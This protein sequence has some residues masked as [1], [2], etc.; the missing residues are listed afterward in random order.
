[1]A[2]D[3]LRGRQTVIPLVNKSGGSVA[4]NDVV[5]LDTANAGAFT[6]TT[7][8]AYSAGS[9]GV[10]LETIASNATG[11]VCTAGYVPGIALNASATLGY[12]VKTHTVAKQ[13]TSVSAIATGVFAQVLGTG[14]APAA[15]LYGGF[16][17]QGAGL[18]DEYIQDLVA[19][20]AVAGTNMTITYN[21]GAGTLT[22]D[23]AGGS[24]TPVR[25]RVYHNATQNVSNNTVTALAFNS[26]QVD[27]SGYHDNATN[28]PRL[29]VPSGQGGLH[30]I[31]G[32]IEFGG[33]NTTGIRWLAIRRNGTD[34]L[35][36]QS[37]PAQN[38]LTQISVTTDIEL[39]AT[40]YVELVFNQTSGGTITVAAGSSPSNLYAC[41]FS[42]TRLGS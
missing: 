12:F 19:A 16:P 26:E 31:K 33:A 35:A 8:G 42:I 40:D 28:N 36:V 3:L 9:I 10:V 1:M 34:Y 17:S 20:M 18:S 24:S 21:D 5:I 7:T 32:H 6:T 22:F 11:R 25:A 15:W 27:A 41:G 29:T 14:T 2:N 37:A 23:A 30:S 39:V 13:G 4:A 38:A